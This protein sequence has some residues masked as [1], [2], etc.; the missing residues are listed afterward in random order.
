MITKTNREIVTERIAEWAGENLK[1]IEVWPG[2]FMGNQKCYQNA[3]Q[4]LEM[5]HSTWAVACIAILPDGRGANLHF[6]N[7]S[8]RGTEDFPFEYRD[9]TLGYQA[10]FITYYFIKEYTEEEADNYSKWKIYPQIVD[11]LQR[12]YLLKVFT[13]EELTRL[14]ISLTDF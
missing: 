10:N 4:D 5:N 12:E 11:D 3:R 13:Q 1:V 2:N 6:V 8:G 14:N 7:K 9:N